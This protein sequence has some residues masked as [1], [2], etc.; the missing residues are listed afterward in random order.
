MPDQSHTA[1][2]T[3]DAATL[4]VDS[5]TFARGQAVEILEGVHPGEIG[6]VL[7]PDPR[8]RPRWLPRRPPERVL[9]PGPPQS[10]HTRAPGRTAGA[11]FKDLR[12]VTKAR[13]KGCLRRRAVSAGDRSTARRGERVRNLQHRGPGTI[14]ADSSMGTRGGL[15]GVLVELSTQLRWAVVRT[16]GQRYVERVQP[17]PNLEGVPPAPGP[18]SDSGRLHWATGEAGLG[19]G[20][21]HG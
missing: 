18:R 13:L 21:R 5:A 4:E 16:T 1:H 6:V 15:G 10:A 17:S 3:E 8:L 12:D 11:P 20:C 9:F 2:S 14:S 7:G 19:R